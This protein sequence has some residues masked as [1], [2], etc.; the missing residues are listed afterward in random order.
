[1]RRRAL[2]LLAPLVAC[3][4]A[5]PATERPLRAEEIRAAGELLGSKLDPLRIEG[6]PVLRVVRGAPD[7]LVDEA[8]RRATECGHFTVSD[9][10]ERR[11]QYALDPEV[12]RDGITFELIDLATK[13]RVFFVTWTR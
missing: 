5:A 13:R 2:V 9:S 1:M 4:T 10:D 12:A 3:A 8:I 11:P 6:Q 7:A